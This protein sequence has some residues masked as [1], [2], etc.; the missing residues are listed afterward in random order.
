MKTN[1]IIEYNINNF[2]LSLKNFYKYLDNEGF[3]MLGVEYESTNND[4]KAWVNY[5]S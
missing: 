5:V 2:I 3:K 1:L 4:F